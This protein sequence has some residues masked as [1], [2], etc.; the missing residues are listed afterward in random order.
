VYGSGR[1]VCAPL[2]SFFCVG[3]GDCFTVDGVVLREEP[4]VNVA[5]QSRLPA[6]THSDEYFMEL[7]TERAFCFGSSLRILS[8]SY[9]LVPIYDI[10]DRFHTLRLVLFGLD[11]RVSF[12]VGDREL[13]VAHKRDLVD[14]WTECEFELLG[15]GVLFVSVRKSELF[16]GKFSLVDKQQQQ[17]FAAKHVSKS[18]ARKDHSSYLVVWEI[19]G[20]LDQFEVLDIIR[21]DTVVARMLPLNVGSYFDA[22]QND[23]LINTYQIRL[24]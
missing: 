18:F 17:L 1:P 2:V 11:E 6:L 9:A 5:L 12:F 20:S 8:T 23:D 19:S 21:N 4:W 15:S 16:V 7:S 13:T 24:T 3:K 22:D 10:V 14:G